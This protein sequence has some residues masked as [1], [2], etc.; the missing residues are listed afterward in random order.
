MLELSREPQ[1]SRTELVQVT[2]Q[3]DS[4]LMR[5][6]ELWQR[7]FWLRWR[8]RVQFTRVFSAEVWTHGQAN[9]VRSRQSPQVQD[10][11]VAGLGSE[12]LR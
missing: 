1:D 3:K 5:T 12:V 4:V 7:W 11:T 9:L 2:R 8:S 10:E 6:V